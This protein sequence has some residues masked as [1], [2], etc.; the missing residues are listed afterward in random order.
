MHTLVPA[1]P[2]RRLAAVLGT[3]LVLVLAGALA[4]VPAAAQQSGDVTVE[5]EATHPA[6]GTDVHYILRVTDKAG[7]PANDELVTV[8]AVSA[9]G[10]ELTPIRFTSADD[11]GRYEGI[12]SYPGAGQYRLRITAVDPDGSLGGRVE[13]PVT[14]AVSAATVPPTTA[15]DTAT[16]AAGADGGFAPADDGTNGS[17]EQAAGDDDD[18]GAPGWL[19]LVGTVVVLGAAVAGAAALWRRW[20]G[21]R[22]GGDDA[23]GGD[24]EGADSE[25]AAAEPRPAADPS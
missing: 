18:G 4:A 1:R 10:D 3:T 11:D 15:A 20:G 23:P 7:E 24:G 5:V 8:A 12:V 21:G 2:V 19:I 25:E 6:G 13:Q 14:V 17:A 22:D 9:G 16:T